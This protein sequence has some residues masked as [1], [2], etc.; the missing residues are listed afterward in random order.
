M[1]VV[2]RLRVGIW[3]AKGGKTT[4]KAPEV[5]IGL[6]AAKPLFGFRDA[7]LTFDGRRFHRCRAR[8]SPGAFFVLSAFGAEPI[9]RREYFELDILQNLIRKR[10]RSSGNRA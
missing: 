3:Y 1:P 10:R 2:A 8:D 7:R 5:F 9:E 4:S 6:L